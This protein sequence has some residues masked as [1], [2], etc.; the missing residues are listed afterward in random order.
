MKGGLMGMDIHLIKGFSLGFWL[1]GNYHLVAAIY[2]IV[3]VTLKRDM[4]IYG[5]DM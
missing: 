4:F 3:F 2:I 1:D 5:N